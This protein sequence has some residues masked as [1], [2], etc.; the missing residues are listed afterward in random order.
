VIVAA[1]RSE[2]MGGVDKL[3]APLAGR[4]LLSYAIDAFMGCGDI[5]EVI[6]VASE[7]NRSA[8]EVLTSPED[9]AG[10]PRLPMR[11]VLGG[12]RRRDSV[13][14]GLEALSPECEYVIV[15][16]GARPRVTGALIKAVLAAARETGAAIAAIPV[17][18]TVKLATTDGIV[19]DTLDRDSLWLAQTPQAFRRDLLLK[20]YRQ[21]PG[22]ATD[23]AGLV[24]ALGHPVRLIEGARENLK[25]T[26]PADLRLAEALLRAHE[27]PATE[28]KRQ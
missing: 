28:S 15:H 18:D 20:A 22:D 5:D 14:A 24:E 12:P 17:S 11:L 6:V 2:R 9:G 26:T 10:K 16:D 1:G 25:V 4:P 21:M 8:V 7:E 27:R 3:L 13:L 19:R 23:D